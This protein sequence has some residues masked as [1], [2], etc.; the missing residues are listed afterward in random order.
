MTSTDI[1]YE[2]VVNAWRDR[3]TAM[4]TATGGLYSTVVLCAVG[5]IARLN[6]MY[7]LIMLVASQT[8][9]ANWLWF[10]LNR[11]QR[12]VHILKSQP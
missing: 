5:L 8:L 2:N 11:A 9:R 12:D 1:E 3:R 7:V 6:P 10:K 4:L